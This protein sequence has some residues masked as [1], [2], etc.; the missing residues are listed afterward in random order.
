MPNWCQNTVTFKHDDNEK[1]RRVVTAYNKGAL[2][3]EFFPCPEPLRDTIAG[4]HPAGT[5][6]QAAL[7]EQS[8]NNV[9]QFGHANWY[10]WSVAEWGTKWDVGREKHWDRVRLKRTA[11]EVKLEFD[12]AWSPP[13]EFYEKMHDELGFS[14]TAHFFEGGMGFCGTWDDGEYTLYELAGNAEQI[15]QRVPKVLLDL[16]H[17]LEQVPEEEE[18]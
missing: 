1:L 4:A 8:R 12:S 18:A 5:P 10:D 7:E 11:T 2:M 16:F 6:E 15:S 14:I 9:A 3:A 17:I 13:I